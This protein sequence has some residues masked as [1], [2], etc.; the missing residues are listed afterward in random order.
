MAVAPTR[1]MVFFTFS[2]RRRVRRRMESSAMQLYDQGAYVVSPTLLVLTD[3]GWRT[4]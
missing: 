1:D 4:L 2:E 3:D